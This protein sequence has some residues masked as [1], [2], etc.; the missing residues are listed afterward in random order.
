MRKIALIVLAAC[1]FICNGACDSTQNTSGI[2]L[3][4]AKSDVITHLGLPKEAG[5][6]D[7]SITPINGS[8]TFARYEWV[9][10]QTR[11]SRDVRYL[12]IYY[13]SSERVAD[14]SEWLGGE[15]EMIS[16]LQVAE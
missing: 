2:K 16:Y 11:Q 5:I 7:K 9:T 13:D 12:L 10:N 15:S 4:M 14:C 8:V 1:I 6:L 3:G